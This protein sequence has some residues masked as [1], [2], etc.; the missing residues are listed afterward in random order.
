MSFR[1]AAGS[2]NSAFSFGELNLRSQSSVRLVRRWRFAPRAEARSQFVRAATAA[3]PG[4]ASSQLALY[5]EQISG[6]YSSNIRCN[7]SPECWPFSQSAPIRASSKAGCGVL[8][9]CANAQRLCRGHTSSGIG[10]KAPM[11]FLR[12]PG[13][14]SPTRARPCVAVS[15]LSLPQTL[16]PCGVPSPHASAARCSLTPRSSG[17]PTAGHQAREAV[18]FIIHFAGLASHRWLP[19]SSNVRRHN[20]QARC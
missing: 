14:G 3:S 4:L 15:P 13:L 11:P 7:V 6:G 8:R 9:P 5:R 12:W 1:T 10:A 17:A 19:L 16:R 2:A 18:L 20:R